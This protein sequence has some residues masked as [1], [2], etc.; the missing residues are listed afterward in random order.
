M[1]AEFKTAMEQAGL[2][3]VEPILA[4]GK[5]HRFKANGDNEPNSWY[6]LYAGPLAAAAFGC[7]KRQINERWSSRNGHTLTREERAALNRTWRE[8]QKLRDL[9]EAALHK[10]AR[11][12]AQALVVNC[13][14]AQTHAYLRQKAVNAHGQVLISNQE[15]TKGWLVLPLQDS[16]GTVHTVQFI[17]E[18]GTKKFLYGGHLSGCYFVLADHANDPLV[19]CEGYATGATIHE[20]TGWSVVC[21]L[22]CGNILAVARAIRAKW[23]SRELIICADN[24]QFTESNPGVSKA[25]EA[26]KLV[27][28][29][30]A[31]PEFADESLTDKPTDFNDLH[32]LVGLTEVRKQLM[33]A[34][35]SWLGLIEDAG[36][37]VCEELPPLVEIVEGLVAEQSK[38]SIVS[39]AKSFKTWTTINLA[40][41]IAHGVP[42]LGRTTTRRR[43]LY[44][45]LELKSNTF[46]RRV[47]AIAKA[48]GIQV[49]RTWLVHLP[50]RGRTAGVPV[51]ELI[52]RIS[53]IARRLGIKVVV[54]D[55]LF[56]INTEGEE[57][58]SKDQTIL[59]NEV[60]RL[61]TEAG[62]TVILNDHS[63]KGNQSEKDPL[64]VIRGSSAK[65]G[66][67]DAAMVLR[68]HKVKACFS[69]DI[70]QRELPPVE[71]FVI[72][73][74]HP[75]MELRP[76]LK[77]EHMKKSKG[78]QSKE[79][80]P[81]RLLS[82]IEGNTAT[83]PISV[84]AWARA[85]DVNRQTLQG[86]MPEM[87]VKGWIRT[88]GEGNSARQY[89]TETG[90]AALEESQ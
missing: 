50:L 27:S 25:K 63:G 35:D 61:T 10:Q 66:D 19:I 46:K 82:A 81:L 78:G 18:D 17:A 26:A 65:G 32:R 55:P 47:Q 29:H 90:F 14:K 21:A 20:A 43:V 36:D 34:G 12:N 45:N 38:L 7:W 1:N 68:R 30:V 6:V 11:Q 24:D 52:T 67:I 74:K 49:E 53:G 2:S 72:G 62:C 56:K 80:D 77:P 88:S 85:A 70:I 89:I 41:C 64:D 31:V 58:S 33:Q 71:P 22:S 42:F 13:P 86:Y 23:T 9:E 40:M 87:R 4:D 8:Q 51:H 3:C 15:S 28:A 60:D 59:M 83:N 69:V 79:H 75:L 54:I 73:W 44:L 48:L 16:A 37:I 5:L 76:D 84:S 39:S 57:N